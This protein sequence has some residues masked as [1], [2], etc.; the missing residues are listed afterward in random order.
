MGEIALGAERYPRVQLWSINDY[1]GGRRP[2]LP[3]PADP[4]TGKPMQPS[5]LA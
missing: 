1:F 5:L 4:E 3:T 2:D